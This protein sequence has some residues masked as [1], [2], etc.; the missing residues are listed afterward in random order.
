MEVQEAGTNCLRVTKRGKT[1]H[2]EEL[3]PVPQHADMPLVVYAQSRAWLGTPKLLLETDGGSGSGGR[4]LPAS[5]MAMG[6]SQAAVA[7]EV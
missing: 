1:H 2:G 5:G 4:K 7:S 3:N 6:I